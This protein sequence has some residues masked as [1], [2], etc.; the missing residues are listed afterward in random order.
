MGVAVNK[1]SDGD[2]QAGS[3]LQVVSIAGMYYSRLTD[4]QVE[5]IAERVALRVLKLLKKHGVPQAG[6]I[7]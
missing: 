6:F 7:D 4:E 5:E 1:L 3:G 2:K